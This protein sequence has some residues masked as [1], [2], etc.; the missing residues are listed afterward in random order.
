MPF[1]PFTGLSWLLPDTQNKTLSII[2]GKPVYGISQWGH[3]FS[4]DIQKEGLEIR[5]GILDCFRVM[6][7][8]VM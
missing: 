8:D 5:D 2:Y 6:L 7:L 1:C 3:S 4:P